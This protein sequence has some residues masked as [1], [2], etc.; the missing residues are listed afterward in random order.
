MFLDLSVSLDPLVIFPFELDPFQKDAIAAL[1]EGHSVVVC[2]P[3]GSGKTLV[4]EYA[5]YR[6]IAHNKRVFYTTPLKALSNQKYRDFQEKFGKVASVGLITGDIL[7]NPGATIVVMTTEIIRNMLYE[8]PIGEVGTSVENVEAVVLDEC[9]YISDRGRGTVWEESIIYCPPKI[10]LVGLSATIGN[11]DALTDWMEQARS[12]EETPA[13]RCVLIDSDYRPVPLQFYFSS[14]KGLFPLLDESQSRLHPHWRNKRRR[15]KRRLRKEDCPQVAQVVRQLRQKDFLPAIYIIFSRRNCDLAVATLRGIDLL[16]SEE[17]MWLQEQLLRF[18]LYNNP[19]L[20]QGLLD[21]C[22]VAWP[23]LRAALLAYFEGDFAEATPA[24]ALLMSQPRDRVQ[25]WEFLDDQ[26][27]IVRDGHLEPLTRGIAAHHAGILPAWKE[28]VEQLFEQSIIKIVFAT[29]TLAAGINMPARTTVISSL[30]RRTNEGHTLLTP[31]EFLQISG[32]AGRRGMDSIG[33]VV[34]V[35]T[36]FEGPKEAAH[37]AS[38]GAEPLRSCFTPSY[39]MVLNLLQ[40]HSLEE[41]KTLLERSFAEYLA[42]KQLKPDQQVIAKLTADLARLNVR[43]GGITDADCK[44]YRKLWERRQVEE[45][46][47]KTLQQQAW[48]ARQDDLALLVSTLP[49][50][51]VMYLRGKFIPQ[52]VP[53]PAVLVG[54][55]GETLICLGQDNHWYLAPFSALVELGEDIPAGATLKTPAF[56]NPR[57]YGKRQEGTPATAEIAAQLPDYVYPP[58]VIA[59][60]GRLASVESLLAKHPLSQQPNP[61][62]ILAAFEERQT[63]QIQLHKSQTRYQK[64]EARRSY[65]WDEFMNLVEVLRHFGALD[66]YTPTP[67]GQAAAA[68]RGENELWLGLALNSGALESLTPE[69]LAAAV[70]ALISEPTRVDSWCDFQPALS[71]MEMFDNASDSRPSLRELA[72]Q[73]IQTQTRNQVTLPVLLEPK[74]VGLVEQWASGCDWDELTEAT[75]LDEGDIVRIL[76]RTVDLLWQIPQV[77]GLSSDLVKSAKAAIS[78]MKRFPV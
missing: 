26:T 72:R 18:L 68:I 6:A 7:I 20:Q 23:D 61:E 55:Q 45:Q 14:K 11:P 70:A 16:S 12:Y 57:R 13:A 69:A 10:Q 32:R 1:N 25:F 44:G 36:P 37:L 47:L 43:L 74:M 46:L 5:I 64:Q 27:S 50:G 39:G 3:T 63:L 21:Y 34:A 78:Q 19:L 62:T 9:H 48:Q 56:E 75:S 30:S 67:L 17:S 51:M 59:Q 52:D 66:E 71:V 31:S 73:L 54:L 8:T 77:P 40:K 38:S 28:L 4:G 65:Y 29:A 33:H 49:P 42:I 24:I 2:A 35:E 60:Q 53:L 15:P 58:E 22:H 41:V 76:R